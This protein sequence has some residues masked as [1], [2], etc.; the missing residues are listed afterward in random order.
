L[1]PGLIFSFFLFLTLSLFLLSFYYIDNPNKG[2]FK[3][4]LFFFLLSNYREEFF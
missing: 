1:N 4:F 3:E 2:S